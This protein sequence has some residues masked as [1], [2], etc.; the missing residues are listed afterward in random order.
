MTTAVIISSWTIL[1]DGSVA[2]LLGQEHPLPLWCKLE[3]VTG[4]PLVPCQP[5]L[6]VAQFT[7]LPKAG[8]SQVAEW[9]SEVGADSHYQI[10]WNE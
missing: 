2:L 4:T 9:I 5:N 10:L 3:D 6:C 7:S 8:S 1:E